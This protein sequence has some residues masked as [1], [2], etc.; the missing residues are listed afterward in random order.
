MGARGC[1]LLD[2]VSNEHCESEVFK[3]IMYSKKKPI[4]TIT[5]ESRVIYARGRKSIFE[6]SKF[7]FL[8]TTVGQY[9]II[10]RYN[11]YDDMTNCR[12]SK[13]IYLLIWRESRRINNSCGREKI[14]RIKTTGKTDFR[15][16]FPSP[17]PSLFGI[18]I[19]QLCG[20]G[21]R[22]CWRNRWICLRI[23]TVVPVADQGLGQVRQPDSVPRGRTECRPSRFHGSRV[24]DQEE[25]FGRHRVKLQT[26]R[27]RGHW[28][29][30][31]FHA[32]WRVT[33]FSPRVTM[34]V[35]FFRVTTYS[36]DPLPFIEYTAEEVKTWGTVFR[37]LTSLYPTH[38]CKE[39]NHVFPLLVQNC[40]YSE[41][42]IPQFEDISNFLKG[43][44]CA[45]EFPGTPCSLGDPWRSDGPLFCPQTVPDLHWGRWAVCCRPGTFWR[46]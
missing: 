23:R 41:K 17:P 35:C 26:V 24:Q 40:G 16:V 20:D 4:V 38:A 12:M 10:I 29:L 27:W 22:S 43:E 2:V 9:T 19:K 14:L 32:I 34:T 21:T 7:F 45:P 42:S 44:S 28:F 5:R 31:L 18:N 37:E 8:T 25:V 33:A 15:S 1:T 6:L 39:Y 46:D 36:G 13:I 3:H 11:K 30:F